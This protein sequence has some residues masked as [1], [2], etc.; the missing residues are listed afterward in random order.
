M[1]VKPRPAFYDGRRAWWFNP[2]GTLSVSSFQINYW[3]QPIS[4]RSVYVARCVA[5]DQGILCPGLCCTNPVP[6]SF[7]RIAWSS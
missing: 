2:R 3:T 7:V 6:A 5:K 4:Y 1:W